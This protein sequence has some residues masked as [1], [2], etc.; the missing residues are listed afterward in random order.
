VSVAPGTPSLPVAAAGRDLAPLVPVLAL[1]GLAGALALLLV[2]RWA[3]VGAAGLVGL[4][5]V[6]VGAATA[7][8]LGDLVALG[9]PLAARGSPGVLVAGSA[10]ATAWPWVALAGGAVLVAAGV[11]GGLGAHRWPGL[12]RRYERPATRRE[13]AGPARDGGVIDTV[14]AWDA[15]DAGDDPTR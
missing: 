4:C 5:G 14:A 11:F 6:G 3:R 13:E 2:T 15:L 7:S 10:T 1:V 8:R 12:S 9:G